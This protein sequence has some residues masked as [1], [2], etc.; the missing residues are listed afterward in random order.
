M[1]YRYLLFW[2][3]AGLCRGTV[4]TFSLSQTY[5]VLQVTMGG[6]GVEHHP[7]PHPLWVAPAEQPEGALDPLF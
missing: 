5:L 3:V 4:K 2:G 7:P 6:E 1:S